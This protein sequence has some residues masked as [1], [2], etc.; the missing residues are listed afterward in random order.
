[1]N[2]DAFLPMIEKKYAKNLSVSEVQNPEDTYSRSAQR[3]RRKFESMKLFLSLA[4]VFGVAPFSFVIFGILHAHL[5]L[6][7]FLAAVF[8]MAVPIVFSHL[9]SG[10]IQKE[11]DRKMEEVN[12]E[13]LL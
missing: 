6:N 1:M 5:G 3:E 12:K 7:L 11:Y 8:M 13:K 4:I 10:V 9:L 2:K